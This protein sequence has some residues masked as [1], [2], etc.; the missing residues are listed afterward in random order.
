MPSGKTH[1][2]LAYT[3][4]IGCSY[5][6][7][8][9]NL[10]N[11]LKYLGLFAIASLFGGLMFGPD[12]DI[13]SVQYK[14]WWLLKFI[15]LPYQA[16]GHRSKKTQS[17]DALFGP[18][19]R[20]IYFFSSIVCLAIFAAGIFSIFNTKLSLS[21]LLKFFEFL[22]TIPLQFHLSFISGLWFGNVIHYLADWVWEF[23]PKCSRRQN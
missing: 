23:M 7:W 15:W 10:A 5:L 20:I 13:K 2:F 17:H 9:Y 22:F 3:T 12:L 6:L 21:F 19:I 1:D 18:I 11:D 8:H 4:T 16:F 14:R